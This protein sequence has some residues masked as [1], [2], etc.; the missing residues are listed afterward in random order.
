[1]N[2][3]RTPAKAQSTNPDMIIEVP[4]WVK[5]GGSP[6]VSDPGYE[7]GFDD[8]P[9]ANGKEVTVKRNGKDGQPDYQ[10]AGW[11][12]IDDDANVKIGK[13][14]YMVGVVV[15]K[16]ID[17]EVFQKSIPLNEL[18]ELNPRPEKEPLTEVQEEIADEAIEEAIGLEDPS[19][20]DEYAHNYT[21]DE[22]KRMREASRRVVDSE[23]PVIPNLG[24][25]MSGESVPREPVIP[26]LEKMMSGEQHEG[27]PATDMLKDFDEDDRMLLKSYALAIAD[28][29][30]AHTAAQGGENVRPGASQEAAQN[31]AWALKQ[32]SPKAKEIASRFAQ[33]YPGK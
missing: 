1:M 13:D 23:N 18:M 2:S 21:P 27:D 24:V 15:E 29:R 28:Q 8:N 19:Q 14:Q 12:I 33:V 25:M 30:E 32:L 20:V 22:I 31:A 26:N 6:E 17:G 10:E 4:D 7:A 9:F 3:E 5:N 11:K 16:E